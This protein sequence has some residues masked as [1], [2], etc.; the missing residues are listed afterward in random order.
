ME[1]PLA[2]VKH[3][4]SR[5]L[6]SFVAVLIVAIVAAGCSAFPSPN[7]D[8]SEPSDSPPLVE[9]TPASDGVS[10]SPGTAQPSTLFM[11]NGRIG[12]FGFTNGVRAL[13][14]DGAAKYVLDCRDACH[15]V[16]ADW[17][18]D[19][20]RLAFA[21]SHPR[22]SEYDGL[23]IVDADGG[24]DRQVMAGS[25][26]YGPAW[27]PDGTRIAYV[28]LRQIF[29]TNPDGSGRVLLAT[30]PHDTPSAPSWS[31]DGS[32]IVYEAGGR[33][34]VMRIDGSA[35]TP[36]EDGFDPVWSP[37]GDAIAYVGG[38]S[39]RD[40]GAC[41]VRETTPT[42]SNDSRLIDLA[43]VGPHPGKCELALGLEWSP[44]GT[45]LAALAYQTDAHSRRG[46]RSAVFIVRA[47]G[48]QPR[49]FTRWGDHPT[50]WG[51]AWQP[52]P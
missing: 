25:E 36:I 40:P 31:P 4:K 26:V 46:V 52:V 44:D 9:S 43:I 2:H 29:V 49:L 48:S 27:S 51:I 41:E 1:Q 5:P 50:W 3:V 35:P 21:A 20:T 42:G 23:H 17:S 33:I 45:R 47:D 10:Q 19:G 6:A 37:I 32:S 7:E 13:S 34:Y 8:G 12:V 14:R 18:P 38:Q 39:M 24:I 28:Q 11:E 16:S 15:Y 30:I 22:G